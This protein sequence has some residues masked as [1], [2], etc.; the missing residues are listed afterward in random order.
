MS[1]LRHSVRLLLKDRSFTITAL[2]TLALCI[3]A[4]TA[5]FSVVRSILLKP[6]PVPEAD[7]LVL[8]YNSYPN[9]GAEKAGAAVPDYY[10]R[11]RDLKSLDIQ[12]MFRR[13]G[14]TL[15]AEGGAERLTAMTAT[16]SFYRMLQVKP[17]V[18]SLFTDADG[19]DGSTRRVLL[20]HAI[21]QNKF[22]GDPFI[23]GR[24]IRLSGDVYQVAGVL[25]ADFVFLRD[26]VDVW[27]PTRFTVQ[28]KSDE[29]RHSNNWTYV[30]RLAPGASVT[31]VQ[32]QLNALQA[33]NDEK[34]PKFKQ[35][36]KDAGY[37]T[38]A[39]GFQDDL[40]SALKPVLYLLWG[41]VLVVLLIGC[42]NI[43]NLMMVRASA[44]AREMAT[45]H[46]I[47]AT[48]GRL[49]VELLT[50]SVVL[51]A[52]GGVLGILLGW[53]ALSAVPLLGLDE[54]PRGNE[55]GL[56]VFSVA[57]AL[58]LTFVV[59]LVI[60]IIPIARLARMNVNAT[61]REEGRG[62][63]VSR[64]TSLLRRGL[65]A[66]QIAL[67]CVLLVGAALL[68]TSFQQVLRID[69]GFAPEGIVSGTIA[70]PAARYPEDA[71][72]V[73]AIGRIVDAARS[74]PGVQLAGATSVIPF[75]NDYNSSVILAEGYVM[76]PGESL[77]SPSQT[78]ATD[79][80][81][82]TM[83]IP[84][85]RGRFFTAGDTATSTPVVIVDE[86]LAAKFWPDQDPIGRRMF[87]PDS[88]EDVMAVT[89]KTRFFNVVGVI[90]EVKILGLA[91]GVEPVGA[92][93]FPFSQQPDRSVFIAMRTSV[94][95]ESVVST[96]RSKIAAIDPELPLYDVRM[97]VN[98]IDDSLVSRRVPMLLAMAFAA[99][100][101]LLSAIGVYGVLA[102]QVSQR[103]REIGIRMALGSTTREVF[104]LVL[105]DG[106]KIA[107]I[108]MAA[109]LIGTYFVGQAMKGLLYNVAP[110]EPIVIGTVAAV[111]TVV[112]L[113]AT[114][115]PARRA[116]RVNPLTALG[117]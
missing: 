59:G 95:S 33:A 109:G 25:P 36:L 107:G 8:V 112:A 77:I 55:I 74:I 67:A 17:V 57:T 94:A 26:D 56:D 49:S 43:A 88:V 110:M 18:G 76:K 79:G 93:Y 115:I 2:L 3:G 51:A 65:A 71:D 84:L 45:R 113:A 7:R 34:F 103:R 52:A 19:D 39:V 20:G 117:E 31:Q 5:I 99:V 11:L 6:L 87:L 40:V 86:R 61:L 1:A 27:L 90:K 97:M 22:N 62:G 81:F 111:L 47:G 23:A 101:L 58:G 4:N 98:Q 32:Q 24:E 91:T 46:A 14:V 68:A 100:A 104:G 38:V 63:T 116:S 9:A 10:D 30:G 73:A 85:V 105:R 37:H 35:I 44:R 78:V 64:S 13:S 80:Y 82:E 66:A 89:P 41:G 70:L 29:R 28:D 72:R 75:G 48:R 69:P 92:Y 60:G 53:W 42:V 16:A 54:I 108:G 114:I 21:W 50:E 12:S 83:Q 96:L 106:L 15:G 102:Y